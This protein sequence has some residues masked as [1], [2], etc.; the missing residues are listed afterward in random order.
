M[1]VYLFTEIDRIFEKMD[2]YFAKRLEESK[3]KLLT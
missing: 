1:T 3:A 2:S